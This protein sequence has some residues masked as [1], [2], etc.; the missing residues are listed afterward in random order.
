MPS[1]SENG[2][3]SISMRSEN[4]PESPSSALQTMYFCAARLVEHG[5]P[6]DAGRERRAAAAAQA[7]LEHFVD[8]RCPGRVSSARARPAVA[9]RARGSR[10]GRADR[11]AR[12]ARTSGAAASRTRDAPRSARG[13]ADA[14][15]PRSSPAAT[16]PG[17]SRCRHRAVGDAA[18]GALDFDQRLEPEQAARTVAAEL[19]LASRARASA[20]SRCAR[21]VGTERERAGI[22]RNV[23]RDAHAFT[24]APASRSASRRSGVTRP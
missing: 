7:G 2:S 20:A 1:I 19:D 16:S 22:A 3:P 17:T 13:A 10:R 14:R 18:R 12:R 8:D 15:R 21:R 6:L 9:A 24:C 5:L 23:D 4:V 11:C